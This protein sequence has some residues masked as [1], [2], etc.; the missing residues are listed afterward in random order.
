[1]K[2]K[3][4]KFLASS[5]VALMLAPAALSV[6]PQNVV[7]ADAVGTVSTNTPVYDGNG[8][9]NGVTLPSGS[10]WKLGQQIT[11]NGVAHY[12]VG[13]NEYIP[14]SVVTN[15]TGATNS[16]DD[17]GTV[18]RYRADNP[19]AGKT[20]TADTVLHVYDI[21]GNDTG[22][23]LPAGSQWKI[24]DVLHANKQ[25]YYQIA[26]N[27]YVSTLNVTLNSTSTTTNTSDITQDANYGKTGTTLVT[28]TVY[29]NNGNSTG[30][31]LPKASQ[32]KLG[33]LMKIGQAAYYQ[34]ATNEWLRSTDLN[35]ASDTAVSDNGSYITTSNEI[36]G[37]TGSVT[38]N[39]EVVNGSGTPIGKTLPA[40]SQ[41]KL[42]ANVL[43]YDK[44]SYYQVASDEYISIAYVRLSTENNTNTSIP[45]P[46]NG[47]IGTTS[48]AQRTYNTST[49]AYDM[50]LP[51]NTSWKID[52][53]VVNKY[54]SYWGEIATNQWV[55]IS[56]VR[57][58]SGL[59]LKDYSYYEPDFATS[60]A[61]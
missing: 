22:V 29:D 44:Q 36:A 55:W 39:V 15:V 18:G 17:T 10:Q 12:Q 26:T 19:D 13:N 6:L 7:N 60:I 45:T 54:G 43:Y 61:K 59:N 50:N 58:N 24:G 49:N 11:L 57:L 46:G 2:N 48:V 53:L 25:V 32:W 35:I 47:L 38:S 37:Q 9:A 42:G 5:A 16:E 52:R 8:K 34:V 33:S 56:S 41:W 30:L 31:T 14:A 27:Q 3:T 28:A 4:S 40:G 21:Y 1:M 51:A 23:T 20:V